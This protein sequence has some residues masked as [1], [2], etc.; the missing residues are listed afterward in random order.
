MSRAHKIPEALHG[1]LSKQ[2]AS[3]QRFLILG[4][5]E[6]TECRYFR[7][8]RTRLRISLEVDAADT[9]PLRL[10]KAAINRRDAQAQRARGS[11][12]HAP[13]DQVWVV[14]DREAKD[15]PRM[16]RFQE[17][18]RLA[19]EEKIHFVVS[20]PSFEVWLLLHLSPVCAPL[21]NGKGAV[22]ALSKVQKKHALPSYEKASY[23]LNFYLAAE[24]VVEA[25]LNAEKLREHHASAS[26]ER[27]WA[28][29]YLASAPAHASDGDPCTDLDQLIAQLN[30]AAH[31][32]RRFPNISGGRPFVRAKS[33]RPPSAP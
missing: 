8:L 23:P 15:S 32:Q 7:E 5:G 11:Q 26:D 31:M 18:L 27:Y 10:V 28:F 17:A 2:R 6:E 21:L 33:Q 30:L 4:E 29:D 9:D 22:A 19:K 3:G 12:M 20:I 24:K 1:R 14:C 13:Y 16:P 25:C